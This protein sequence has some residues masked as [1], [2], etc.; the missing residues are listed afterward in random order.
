MKTYDLIIMGAGPAGITA[1]IYAAR[2]KLKFLVIT[3]DIGGQVYAV[4]LIG[5]ITIILIS[6]DCNSF[7]VKILF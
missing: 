2:R 5:Y 7:N 1:A 6:N 3:E 4:N